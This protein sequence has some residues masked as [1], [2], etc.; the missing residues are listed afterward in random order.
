MKINELL[1]DEYKN[2]K[3]SLEHLKKT[4]DQLLDRCNKDGIAQNF[5]CNSEIIELANTVK[6]LS[7]KLY[8]I[9]NYLNKED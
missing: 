4:T 2:Y 7:Y 1:L 6:F 5:S 8:L 9:Q 3:N